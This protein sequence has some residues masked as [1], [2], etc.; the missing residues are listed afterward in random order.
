MISGFHSILYS[1]DPE[2]TRAFLRDVLRWPHTDAGE[3]WLIFRTPPSEVG[4][5]PTTGPE[6]QQWATV[7]R[8]EVS[9]MCDDIGATVAELRSRGAEVGD[10]VVDQGYGLVTTV[11][12]PG[13]GTVHLFEPRYDLPP[14]LEG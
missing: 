10:E 8:H 4:V 7:P 5:H 13:A 1:D 6:G 9:L 12:I 11:A 3:G 14:D 2:A